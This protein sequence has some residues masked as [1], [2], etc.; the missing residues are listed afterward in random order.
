MRAPPCAGTTKNSL[1]SPRRDGPDPATGPAEAA[2]VAVAGMA[3]ATGR[4]DRTVRAIASLDW[5]KRWHPLNVLPLQRSQLVPGGICMLLTSSGDMFV[6]G[7]S[8]V[9]LN[10]WKCP[11]E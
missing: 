8:T 3:G 9:W 6:R 5:V 11:F 10:P 7:P 4:M 2:A 1:A